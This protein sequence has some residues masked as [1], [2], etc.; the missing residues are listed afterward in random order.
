[1]RVDRLD[2]RR[3][4]DAILDVVLL[5][6]RSPALGFADRVFH[7]LRDLIGV[8]N[9]LSIR[10]SRGSSHRLDQ[11][12]FRTQNTFLVGIEYRNKTHFRKIQSLAQKI[13]PDKYVELAAAQIAQDRNP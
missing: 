9:R 13:D 6:D 5:L 11:R 7:G 2:D 10:V 12:S 4:R 3:R 1:R 8:Q